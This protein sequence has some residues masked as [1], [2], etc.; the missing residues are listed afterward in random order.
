MR[1]DPSLRGAEGPAKPEGRG[2]LRSALAML[3]LA[4]PACLAVPDTVTPECTVTADCDTANGEVCEEGICWG[5]PPPG[6]FAALISP[7]G[8]RTGDVAPRELPLLEISQDGYLGDLALDAPVTY[9]G[10]I[11]AICP[12]PTADCETTLLGA[13]IIVTRPAMF[14]GGPGY[15]QIVQ[16]D[17]RTGAF[18]ITLPRT[19][20][21]DPSYTVTVVPDGR[22]DQPT[23]ITTAQLVPPLRAQIRVA[24]H[25]TGRTLDLGALALATLDGRIVDGNGNGQ[26]KYRVVALGRWEENGPVTEI[27]TVDYTG[28]DGTFSLRLS[29]ELPENSVVELV[30]RPYGGVLPTLRMQVTLSPTGFTS[31]TLVAPSA[32][33]K[34]RVPLRIKG[35]APGGEVVGVAGARVTIN[36]AI[37]GP[38]GGTFA[39]FSAEGITG[40]GGLVELDLL[41]GE[42]VVPSYRISVV[43]PANAKVGVVFAEPFTLGVPEKRLPDR[44]ALRGRLRDVTGKPLKDAQVTVRP[45]LRWQWSLSSVPQAFVAGIPASTTVTIDTGEFVVFVDR[46]IRDGTADVWAYYD[47]A[48]EPTSTSNAPTWTELEVDVPRDNQLSSLALPEITLPDAAHIHGRVLDPAGVELKGAEL[49][50]FQGTLASAALCDQVSNAPASCP[51]PAVLLGR[52]ASD[53]VGV[54]RLT[55]PRP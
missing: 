46:V 5:N 49:K 4:V 44:I 55:L 47:L 14:P 54:V 43:P 21:D 7:P 26:D 41:D 18:A 32:G 3:A 37:P 53:D 24:D 33:K 16:S 39:T 8:E 31:R 12:P 22:D 13:T 6:P 27:S 30:A 2:A 19:R 50:I 52:G 42:M 10:A 45:S 48:F 28:S 25:A 35:T 29:N 15:R 17:P 34:L 1:L 40:E 11:R 38:P 23:N 20:P 9:A 51:I 36:G